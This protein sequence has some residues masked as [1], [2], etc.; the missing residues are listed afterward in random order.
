MDNI[1]PPPYPGPNSEFIK[2]PLGAPEPP[3]G[4]PVNQNSNGVPPPIIVR[5]VHARTALFGPYPVEMDCPY[6]HNHIVSH[7]MK[8]PG[9]LPW[10]IMAICFVLG[11][12]LLIPWCLCCLPF[13][14]DSCLDVLHTCPSCKRLV[15]R[16]ARL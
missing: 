4:I 5:A 3:Q 14:I 11:F 10:I 2:V 8:V 1:P 6:C 9:V 15:G 7:T 12:F 13:C 16:F